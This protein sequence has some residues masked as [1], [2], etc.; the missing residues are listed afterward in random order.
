METRMTLYALTEQMAVI[1]AMLED[2]GGELTPEL[3][4]QW[5]ETRESLL[6]KVDNY[7][8]LIQ[9]LKAY[10]ENIKAEQD[11]LAKLKKTADN[12][13]RRIKDHIK[14][15][16]EQFGL[17]SIEGNLCK[18]SLSSSTATEVDED[19]VLAPYRIAIEMLEAK[20][21]P[22]VTIEAKI[23]KAAVKEATKELPEGVNLPGVSFN[24]STNLTIK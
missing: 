20:L 5:M 3:E 21:P 16:M 11:R 18:M 2:T 22:Y 17:K 8:A 14:S 13:L 1:E 6:A 7:N 4:E 23:S 19:T 10:S 9:K 12:S 24:K 15:T